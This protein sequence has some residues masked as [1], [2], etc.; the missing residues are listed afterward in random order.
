MEEKEAIGRILP[1]VWNELVST[2]DE[3]LIELV[4]DALDKL[5]EFR[6]DPET[7]AQ[8]LASLSPSTAGGPSPPGVGA[9]S[10][11]EPSP[12]EPPSRERPKAME[13][14]GKRIEVRSWS[15]LL[16]QLSGL[17][18]SLHKGDFS[19]CLAL[20]GTVRAYFSKGAPDPSMHGPHKVPG[21]PYYV[22]TCFSATAIM[23]RCNQLLTHFGYDVADLHVETY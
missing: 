5:F 16:V 2:K 18:Y 8:F 17:M 15:D 11:E 20:R 22:E 12:G 14:R 19:R 21:S 9:S 4:N 10:V 3:S 1:K 6:A 23:A 7:I 13:F